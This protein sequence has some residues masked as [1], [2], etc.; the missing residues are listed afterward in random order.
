MRTLN[1]V[2]LIGWLLVAP[3]LAGASDPAPRFGSAPVLH[4][5]SP[6]HISMD[7]RDKEIAL[8]GEHFS[9]KTLSVEWNGILYSGAT[10]GLRHRPLNEVT[11]Q[12]PASM[13]VKPGENVVRL[14][15]TREKVFSN[16]IKIRV[17]R[18]RAFPP[19]NQPGPSLSALDHFWGGWGDGGAVLQEGNI[20]AFVDLFDLK[21]VTREGVTGLPLMGFDV[22]ADVIVQDA[23]GQDVVVPASGATAGGWRW[24]GCGQW[25]KYTHTW[26]SVLHPPPSL[27][28]GVYSVRL[29]SVLDKAE[30]NRLSLVVI[31]PGTPPYILS[32][33][34]SAVVQG[35]SS[36]F[37]SIPLVGY[38]LN[39]ASKVYLTG[40]STQAVSLT[41]QSN[42]RAAFTLPPNLAPG[43]YLVR[44]GDAASPLSNARRLSVIA[45]HPGQVP[46]E[47][48]VH[49]DFNEFMYVKNGH[50][51]HWLLSGPLRFVD[52]PSA[53]GRRLPFFWQENLEFLHYAGTTALG[54]TQLDRD[55]GTIEIQDYRPQDWPPGRTEERHQFNHGYHHLLNLFERGG[56]WQSKYKIN[57]RT[58]YYIANPTSPT[59]WGY[60]D[61]W[62]HWNGR[63]IE[64]EG[65]WSHFQV[66]MRD[67]YEP[68]NTVVVVTDPS[69]AAELVPPLKDKR[70]DLKIIYDFVDRKE[71]AILVKVHGKDADYVDRTYRWS[72]PIARGNERVD[73]SRLESGWL[74]FGTEKRHPHKILDS[75]QYVKSGAGGA[76]GSLRITDRGFPPPRLEMFPAPGNH[77]GLH[78][79]GFKA[80]AIGDLG[81]WGFSQFFVGCLYMVGN[82]FALFNLTYPIFWDMAL[83]QEG[84][85]QGFLFKLH[86]F[87]PL[88]PGRYIVAVGGLAWD[89]KPLPL[90]FTDFTVGGN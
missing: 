89:G 2:W 47:V 3:V 83:I 79:F 58:L 12:I 59:A 76:I 45:N 82:E 35:Y 32:L 52:S 62:S 19:V 6:V 85:E 7:F 86:D 15:D 77:P 37:P 57:V 73:L 1:S 43:D 21:L 14:Y 44:L 25:P 9:G 49:L 18:D 46:P 64:P 13:I 33:G 60:W 36:S 69:F 20:L 63:T 39:Q 42:E 78:Q 71:A 23:S 68:E 66:F 61:V 56:N 30:S 81:D 51:D 55:R 84:P 5:A 26:W 53:P 54:H 28:A 41:V 4:V 34:R 38:N 72:R 24:E 31:P 70:F 80:L 75:T 90:A 74:D 87:G 22:C 16:P 8:W 48:L 88:P 27:K 50:P 29:R 67:G 10:F 65:T 40:T 17:V 11:L